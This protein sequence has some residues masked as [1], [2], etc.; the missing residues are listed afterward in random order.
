MLMKPKKVLIL[1][2][3]TGGG[4]R[5]AAEAIAEA[6]AERY[7][8]AARVS[9]VD[10]WRYH[11]P[12]PINR[13]GG[14]YSWLVSDG[15]WLWKSLWKLGESEK[16]VSS[17][18][19]LFGPLVQ[20]PFS[21][22][23]RREEPDVVVSVHSLITYVPRWVMRR[24]ELEVPFI[25]VVTDLV[26]APA[27][28]FCPDVD[29]CIVPTEPARRRGIGFGMPP[30]KVEVIGLPV[31]LKFARPLAT[32]AALRAKL[33]LSPGKPAVLVV[34]GA[35]GMGR[36]GDIARAI[37]TSG[38]DLQMMIVSGR[39]RKLQQQLEEISWEV[40]TR[41]FGFVTNMPELMGAADAIVTKA[42]PGTISEAC[43]VG[44]P[45]FLSG[46]VPGQENG[47]IPYVL[48]NGIGTYTEEPQRIAAI[49][50]EWLQPG[51]PAL[52]D[53]AR[54]AHQLGRPQ[55]AFDI[56]RRILE[57][58]RAPFQKSGMRVQ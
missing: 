6:V 43:I 33:N 17:L 34:G 5:S 41:V 53:M 54:R 7:G 1:M 23:L 16:R 45:I 2:S 20:R 56:A 44:L 55:A 29:L 37:A 39:N 30:E 52:S 8:E 19:Q 12:V 42:G 25:T 21:E 4:H 26:S 15:L 48:N 9:I 3:D 49:L 57:P 28:W 13:L 35:E 38:L 32:K 11:T 24:M 10:A 51:N 14:T 22:M 40:P 46:F 47:N 58:V 50:A 18:G 36:V 27:A 31:S